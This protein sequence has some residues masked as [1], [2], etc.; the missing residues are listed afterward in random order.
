LG[1]KDRE[2]RLWTAL[3]VGPVKRDA[4]RLV[5]VMFGPGQ[6]LR[7]VA[8]RVRERLEAIA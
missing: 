4:E 2:H 8:G 3:T 7:V 1:E 6:G 5:S